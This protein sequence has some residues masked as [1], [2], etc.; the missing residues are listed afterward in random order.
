MVGFQDCRSQVCV[1]HAHKTA[2]S[3]ATNAYIHVHGV[4]DTV[5]TAGVLTPEHKR[6][7]YCALCDGVQPVFYVVNKWRSRA[8]EHPVQTRESYPNLCQQK[9]SRARTHMVSG[10]RIR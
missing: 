7:K 9:G 4:R 3:L 6:G 2:R 5:S 1:R 10:P 8:V